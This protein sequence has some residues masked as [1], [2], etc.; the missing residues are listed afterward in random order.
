MV[1]WVEFDLWKQLTQARLLGLE[2]QEAAA[3]W[4]ARE[5]RST[6]LPAPMD[7][8]LPTGMEEA[9][10]K[11]PW[12]GAHG[13]PGVWSY[14]CPHKMLL[15]E[16][17]Q[18]ARDKPGWQPSPRAAAVQVWSLCLHHQHHLGAYEDANSQPHPAPAG[19]GPALCV[20]QACRWQGRRV[21][22][23]T[24][25]SPLCRRKRVGQMQVRVVLTSTLG[26]LTP[27]QL[28]QIHE[29]K[30]WWWMVGWCVQGKW[31]ILKGRVWVENVET[32]SS[33]SRLQE[34]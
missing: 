26:L 2:S 29:W 10:W 20:N 23:E 27:I 9:S 8:T 31:Q 3:L 7:A 14:F 18:I 33:L 30:G 5:E 13:A 4:A 24:W 15:S 17:K 25:A 22:F 21:E 34:Q 32:N 1:C 6:Q 12:T 19:A 28:R 11:E 16:S